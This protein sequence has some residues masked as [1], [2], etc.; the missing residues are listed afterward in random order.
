MDTAEAE[1][2]AQL[3]SLDDELD[4]EDLDRLEDEAEEEM[5]QEIAR[6]EAADVPAASPSPAASEDASEAEF[7]P[8]SR[9]EI[10]TVLN[11]L[12][13]H[14]MLECLRR[15]VVYTPS[16]VCWPPLTTRLCRC[17]CHLA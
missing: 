3:A 14:G 2:L 16:K 12:R 9:E 7:G 15:H 10:S 5:M 8:L 11:D 13:E 4:S 17:C 6:E 1:A